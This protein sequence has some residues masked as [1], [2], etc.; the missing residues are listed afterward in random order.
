MSLDRAR[1]VH[2]LEYPSQA[3][4]VLGGVG[5]E[6]VLLMAWTFRVTPLPPVPTVGRDSLLYNVICAIDGP[7]SI[8]EQE[9][10][11]I[12][13]KWASSVHEAGPE[14]TRVLTSFCRVLASGVND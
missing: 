14:T 12:C 13:V 6:Q 11:N 8:S 9:L 10:C 1:S 3:L 4:L 2:S 7:Y 5:P